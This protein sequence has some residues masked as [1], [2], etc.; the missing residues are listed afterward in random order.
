MVNSHSFL[1]PRPPRRPKLNE[2]DIV[3][4]VDHPD[5]P[6]HFANET[7]LGRL[8]KVYVIYSTT[9]PA[10]HT[11]TRPKFDRHGNLI[12]CRWLAVVNFRGK[13]GYTIERTIPTVALVKLVD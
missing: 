6:R 8:G 11:I 3:Q 12:A 2:G 1:T 10:R 7:W 4:I 9:Y 13:G 5:L